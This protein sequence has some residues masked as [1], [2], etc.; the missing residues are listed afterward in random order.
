MLLKIP[1]AT[2]IADNYWRPGNLLAD[3][4]PMT[5]VIRRVVRGKGLELEELS[6]HP[7]TGTPLLGLALPHWDELRTVNDACARLFAAMRY[8]SFHIALTVEGP[9]V[10]EVNIW[11]SSLN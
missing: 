8:H 7:E 10:V 4:D 3:L 6:K 9:L 11:M 2:S 5:G 1:A